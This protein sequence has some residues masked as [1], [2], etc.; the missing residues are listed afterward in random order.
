MDE[1]NNNPTA[2]GT[3]SPLASGKRRKLREPEDNQEVII[4]DDLE[5]VNQLSQKT[6]KALALEAFLKGSVTLHA[7]ANDQNTVKE[8]SRRYVES[9]IRWNERN[10]KIARFEDP[11]FTPHAIRL[12]CELKGSQQVTEGEQFKQLAEKFNK[13]KA[14]FI[15]EAR[16]LMKSEQN[17][18]QRNLEDMITNQI[19]SFARNLIEDDMLDREYAEDSTQI[20]QKTVSSLLAHSI[21]RHQDDYWKPLLFG[22]NIYTFCEKLDPKPHVML[23]TVAHENKGISIRIAHQINATFGAALNAYG[24]GVKA[25]QKYEKMKQHRDAKAADKLTEDVIMKAETIHKQL[26]AD[27]IRALVKETI[28]SV[29]KHKGD[30]GN[31][32]KKTVT[33]EPSQ[34]TFHKKKSTGRTSTRDDKKSNKSTNYR[35]NTQGHNRKSNN[36]NNNGNDNGNTNV[37]YEKTNNDRSISTSRPRIK[38][39]DL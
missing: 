4:I 17:L 27:T 38:N 37:N 12:N 13:A 8:V 3:D 31:G 9:I 36:R 2:S 21:S 26:D 35:G 11:S 20:D 32:R 18:E 19:T 23:D 33:F 30:T 24:N 29:T 5:T 15:E 7:A 1:N 28:E 14:T 10:K 34:S 6:P 39:L 16:D 25:I 22:R